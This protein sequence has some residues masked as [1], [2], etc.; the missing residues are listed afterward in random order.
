VKT[1][2]I[3]AERVTDQSLSAV[4]PANGVASVSVSRNRPDRGEASAILSRSFRNPSRFNPAVR[5]ELV[6]DDN[7]V[8]TVFDAVSFAYG[9]G[10]FSDAEM[11]VQAPVPA[12]AA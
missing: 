2:T 5:I 3:I 11:W 9:A 6:V 12:L 8:D 1:I 4:V 7:T 10:L